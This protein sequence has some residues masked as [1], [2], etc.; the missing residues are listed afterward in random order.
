M[1]CAFSLGRLST[2]KTLTYSIAINKPRDHVFNKL[3]D[4]SV[5]PGWSKAWGEGMTYEGQWIEGGHICY[6]DHSKGGT[7]VVIE[8]MKAG[9]HI[10]TRH[11]AMVNPQA[12]EVEPT[13]DMMRK[14]IG[15]RE[16]YFFRDNGDD[17]TTFEVVMVVDGAFQEMFDET[18]PKALQYFKEVC[19][20]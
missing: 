7:K 16:D 14:W 2:M 6:H 8:S 20:R 18:W 15:S 1:P 11:I 3:L 19:E 10:K 9:E 12:E 5:Y 13:D 4:K 17:G